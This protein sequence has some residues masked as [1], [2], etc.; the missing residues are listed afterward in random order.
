MCSFPRRESQHGSSP[1]PGHRPPVRGRAAFGSR[2]RWIQNQGTSRSVEGQGR[3]CVT[4]TAGDVAQAGSA[5]RV[6]VGPGWAG[7]GS[8]S[9]RM[10]GEF[11]AKQSAPARC[12]VLKPHFYDL[13]GTLSPSGGGENTMRELG[14]GRPPGSPCGACGQGLTPAPAEPARSEV[15]SPGRRGRERGNVC[16]LFTFKH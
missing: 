14:P 15:Q 1:A 12:S 8:G 9:Q 16:F 5:A 2:S 11:P 7:R 4:R 13:R 3:L 6:L 10:L